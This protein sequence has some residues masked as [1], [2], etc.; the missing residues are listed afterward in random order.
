VT[1]RATSRLFKFVPTDDVNALIRYAVAY[2]A[3]SHGVGIVAMT[4]MSSHAHIL[5]NDH[6]GTL[7]RFT[8]TLN[9]MVACALNA[10]RGERGS[11]FERNNVDHKAV[12]GRTGATIILAYLAANPVEAGC[13]E[14]GREW[15]G[16]RSHARAMGREAKE[17]PRPDHYF[18]HRH[19]G[20][21]G[22]L[23]ATLTMRYELPLCVDAADRGQFLHEAELA[24]A[25]AEANAR[26]TV[27]AKGRTFL[28]AA[29]CRRASHETRA[30][31]SEP[32]G[33]GTGPDPILAT[34]PA[35]KRHEEDALAHFHDA[36]RE[37]W[38]RWQAGER[39]VV[40]PAGTWHLVQCHHA[41]CATLPPPDLV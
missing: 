23:P 5:V 30:R 14:Y 29:A 34:D 15:P 41:A 22:D 38:S 24:I 16:V 3:E 39:D 4:W 20:Y 28:G 2:A 37:S 33:L 8:Q 32:T 36:Y 12:I 7:P 6:D 31:S 21:R 40:F 11:V 18:C 10:L 27:L 25:E 1:V 35:Q 17:I 26:A 19:L 9:T 13:V